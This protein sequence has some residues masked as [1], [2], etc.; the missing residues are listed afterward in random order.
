VSRRLALPLAALAVVAAVALGLLARDVRRWQETVRRDDVR[1]LVSPLDPGLW[2][3]PG[4]FSGRGARNLLAIDDD[5]RFRDAERLFVRGHVPVSTFERE[6]ARLGARGSA[7]AL[8]DAVS[9]GDGAAWRRARAATLLGMLTFEDA[10]GDAENGAALVRRALHL[11]DDAAREDPRADDA[12]FDLELVLTL[13]R[14]QERKG[15]EP[16]GDQGDAGGGVGA[17]VTGIGGG[18]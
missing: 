17:G 4:S 2:T 1:F 15:R 13:L 11:F 8:L 16:G 9:G 6:K 18:Y 7:A 14:E 10:Q 5:L 12:K 3:G